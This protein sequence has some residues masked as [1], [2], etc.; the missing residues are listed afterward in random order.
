LKSTE[1][2]SGYAVA[3]AELL[4]DEGLSEVDF[5]SLRVWLREAAG[6]LRAGSRAVSDLAV[7][8]RDYIDRMAGMVKAMAVLRQGRDHLEGALAL[9]ERLEGMRA[10]ELVVQYRQVS[11][12]FRDAFPASFGQLEAT[13]ESGRRVC[14]TADY[15]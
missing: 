10:E 12:R 2:Q 15:K 4:T 6:S 7:L 13:A 14:R 3:T 1:E 9:I 8:R 5:D 11:A